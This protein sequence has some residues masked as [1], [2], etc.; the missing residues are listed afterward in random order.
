MAIEDFEVK[1]AEEL[2]HWGARVTKR[3]LSNFDR[4]DINKTAGGKG[5]GY[6]GDLYRSIWWTVHNASGGNQALI[7]FYFMSYAPYVQTG[8]GRGAPRTKLPPMTR[9]ESIDRPD[10]SKRKAKPFL[11]S[12][13]RYHLRWLADRLFQQYQYGGSLYVVKGLAD[14]LGDQSITRKW[15]AEHKDKFGQ[16]EL[17][18]LGVG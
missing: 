15:I 12:E 4:L 10:G 7:E 8:T 2:N 9:M 3:I 11:M 1:L 18:H 6:T 13:L 16:S 5:K 17:E 14:G